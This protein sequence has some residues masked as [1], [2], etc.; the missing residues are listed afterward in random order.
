MAL[1]PGL[2]RP[3]SRVCFEVSTIHSIACKCENF[4]VPPGVRD[5]VGGI[6]AT[7][8]YL[9]PHLLPPRTGGTSVAFAHTNMRPIEVPVSHSRPNCN[10]R[11]R[12][13]GRWW[14]L[15][16]PRWRSG[17][18]PNSGLLVAPESLGFA[19]P[20]TCQTLSPKRRK[21][22]HCRHR[23]SNGRAWHLATDRLLQMPPAACQYESSGC[24]RIGQ[25][26]SS[27]ATDLR[28]FPI[29]VPSCVAASCV[30]VPIPHS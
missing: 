24:H 13:T 15:R 12:L 27:L 18:S 6:H 2:R 10:G 23:T 16:S 17:G 29:R 25:G 28:R 20:K 8:G 30:L 7:F 4:E 26:R 22:H 3:E 19:T 1:Q 11:G 5:A 21:S 14:A 9:I